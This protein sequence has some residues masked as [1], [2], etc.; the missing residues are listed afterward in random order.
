MFEISFPEFIGFIIASGG[1]ILGARR[2]ELVKLKEETRKAEKERDK[3]ELENKELED[4]LSDIEKRLHHLDHPKNG[5]VPKMTKLCENQIAT[6]LEASANAK[7]AL[8]IAKN[9]IKVKE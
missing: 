2:F 8:I 7:A 4:R 9:F 3:A 6:N 1:L 5:R